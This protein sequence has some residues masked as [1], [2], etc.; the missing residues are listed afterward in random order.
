MERDD[1]YDD[2]DD[3]DVND[4]EVDDDDVLIYGERLGVPGGDG[5]Q[6]TQV[7]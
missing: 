1:D 2:D 6:H 3:D 4:D 5:C 7:I